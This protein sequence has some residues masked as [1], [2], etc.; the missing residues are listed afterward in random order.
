MKY[1]RQELQKLKQLPFPKR[2]AYIWDYYKIPIFLIAFFI[3]FFCYFL[4]PV[5]K[6][7]GKNT[8][9]SIAIIDSSQA[10]KT[11]TS[12]L[13]DGLLSYLNGD[14]KK[15]VILI[16]TSG[17]T[18][19]N[20][21]STIKNSILLSSVGE[22]DIVICNEDLY[23]TY[24]SKGAFLNWDL[25][26]DDLRPELSADISGTALDLSS[27]PK[28]NELSYTDYQPVYACIPVSCRHPERAAAFINYL[29]SAE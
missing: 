23:R 20:S 4:V 26:S 17:G 16:D 28:W 12:Q 27:C 24:D 8:V 10:A 15:D 2:M 25:L 29:Y 19:D 5:I 1:A 21:S 6:N 3:L 13:S 7:I 9:M 18:Y 11:D 14:S 22:N